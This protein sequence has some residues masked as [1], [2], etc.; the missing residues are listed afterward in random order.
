[1]NSRACAS[2]FMNDHR[3]TGI[4]GQLPSSG[5]PG[6]GNVLPADARN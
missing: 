1:M 2:S 6:R 3:E 5:A 4:V